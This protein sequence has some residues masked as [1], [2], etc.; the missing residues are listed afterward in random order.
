MLGLGRSSM[1][2]RPPFQAR[3]EFII[4]ITNV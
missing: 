2:G 4:E 3:N 1:P